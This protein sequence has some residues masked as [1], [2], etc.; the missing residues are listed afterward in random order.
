M[1]TK[2]L[3]RTITFFK[4]RVDALK[5]ARNHGL[6]LRHLPLAL[7]KGIRHVVEELERNHE[8]LKEIIFVK[9]G[10]RVPTI[11]ILNG[12]GQRR[13]LNEIQS[14]QYRYK[15]LL[16][17][18]ELETE[19]R[20]K[21]IVCKEKIRQLLSNIIDRLPQYNINENLQ[22]TLAIEI[23]N[24]INKNETVFV[25]IAGFN[26]KIRYAKKTNEISFIIKKQNTVLDIIDKELSPIDA[27]TFTNYAETYTQVI[28]LIREYKNNA[29]TD[30]EFWASL[31]ATN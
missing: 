7:G 3:S 29:F 21:L 6:R 24:A 23:A 31:N 17:L 8:L 20:N 22:R 14:E 18:N 10:K 13:G 16:K 1:T 19:E 28:R 11:E 27:K 15:K 26:I 25:N 4:N 12:K 30:P 9:N 5:A 2:P